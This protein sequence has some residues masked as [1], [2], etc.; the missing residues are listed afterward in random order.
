M[1]ENANSPSPVGNTLLK[2]VSWLITGPPGGQVGGAAVAE[3]A[4]AQAHVLV[5]RDRELAARAGDVVAVGVGVGREVERVPHLP[6]VALE[7]LL[8]LRLVAR[9]RQL[10][11]LG[12]ALRQVDELQELVVLAP[13][14]ALAVED[15]VAPRLAPV[16][17]RREL[18]A[19]RP[20]VR[21]QKSMTTGWRVGCSGKRSWNG[22][23]QSGLP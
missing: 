9:Q 8:V 15:H 12:R 21:C 6:A 16:A 20:A 14:V 10:E 22:R 2:P 1:V 17:D 5:L 23:P 19:G 11:R 18:L 13:A 7:H 3:P 4:G